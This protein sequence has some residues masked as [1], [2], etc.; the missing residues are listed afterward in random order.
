MLGEES[1]RPGLEA[2]LHYAREAKSHTSLLYLLRAGWRPENTSE[3]AQALVW[4]ANHVFERRETAPLLLALWPHAKT[5]LLEYLRSDDATA[6]EIAARV[7]LRLD[8]DELKP[9]LLATLRERGTEGFAPQLTRTFDET[10][11]EA[12]EAWLREHKKKK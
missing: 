7:A 3:V 2:A 10:L 11:S 5:V 9:E 12:G 1:G 8:Q 4:D 6:R